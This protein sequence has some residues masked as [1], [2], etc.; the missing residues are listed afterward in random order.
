LPYTAK[1]SHGKNQAHGK[2]T[3]CPCAQTKYTRKKTS[4]Q[5]KVFAVG[6]PAFVRKGVVSRSGGASLDAV[7]REQGHPLHWFYRRPQCLAK[8]P[9]R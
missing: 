4:T 3:L 1:K 2:H 5:Q 6:E 7:C 9:A 8:E